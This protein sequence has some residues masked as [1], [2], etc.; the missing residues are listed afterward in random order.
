MNKKAN[1]ECYI[2]DISLNSTTLTLYI[3]DEKS[4]LYEAQIK[5]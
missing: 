5:K 3:L 2:P 4:G 1:A